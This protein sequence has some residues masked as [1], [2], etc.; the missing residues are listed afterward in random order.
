MW[1]STHIHMVIDVKFF[2]IFLNPKARYHAAQ[3][4]VRGVY[5][6]PGEGLNEGYYKANP[7]LKYN[8]GAKGIHV[9]AGV[10]MGK[11]LVWEYIEGRW[12]SAEA[13]RLYKGPILKALREAYPHRRRFNVLEDNDPTG[14]KS[15]AGIDAKAEAGIDAFEI[16]KR[17]PQLNVCD[18]FLWKQ[19]NSG[20]R[21]TERNWPDSKREK[22]PAFLRRLTCT[23]KRIPSPMILAAQQSMK[24]RCQLLLDVEGGQIEG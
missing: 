11:V 3:T 16:P 2:P 19:V 10:G 24:R 5:R 18:Y 8:S 23:A 22:R 13:A 21:A 17:S 15:R 9:L 1:W 7:K 12:N 14:F 4:G 6:E 20:M